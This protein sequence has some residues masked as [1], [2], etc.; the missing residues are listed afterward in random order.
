MFD[1]EERKWCVYMHRCKINS[2][3][4]IGQTCQMPREK[5]W[6][7]NGQHYKQKR[8]N[9]QYQNPHF[10]GAINLYGWENF[11]HCILFDNLTIDEANR[12]EEICIILFRSTEQEYGYN[13]MPGGK[14]KVIPEESKKKMSIAKKGKNTG[15]ESYWYGKEFPEEMK[16]KMSEAAK[17]RFSIPENTNFYGKHH[18]EESKRKLSEARLGKYTG[19]DAYWSKPTICVDLN[20]LLDCTMDFEKQF[21]FCHSV[22][23][24]ACRGEVLQA[25]GHY[26]I[27]AEDF[28]IERIRELLMRKVRFTDVPVVCIETGQI[29]DT[30]VDAQNKTGVSK[31]G[32]H[33]CLKDQ[34]RTAGHLHWRRATESEWLE[35]RSIWAD[36]IINNLL[37]N[38]SLME[39]IKRYKDIHNKNYNLCAI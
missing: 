2:K 37:S 7:G 32:I 38:K 29:F 16:K 9:G 27:Y 28:D 34:W 17:L 39:E 24:G 30:K 31:D 19:K 5:R 21:G 25:Y 1:K 33:R 13:I 3:V 12:I 35:H 8:K 20:I 22:V 36:K 15:A 26:F 18:T 14:N 4:Y 6:G 11:E 23:S 10:A